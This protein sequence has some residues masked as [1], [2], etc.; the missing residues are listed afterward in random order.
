MYFNFTHDNNTW[1]FI[2]CYK[3]QNKVMTK[4]LTFCEV[5]IC[6]EGFELTAWPCV[7]LPPFNPVT[8]TGPYKKTHTRVEM[9]LNIFMQVDWFFTV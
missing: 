7:P 1:M 6:P 2:A 9:L 3:T 8:P 5:V 4:K